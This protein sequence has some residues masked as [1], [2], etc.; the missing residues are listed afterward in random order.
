M[1]FKVLEPAYILVHTDMMLIDLGSGLRG[2]SG[3]KIGL[4]C[5]TGVT[6]CSGYVYPSKLRKSTF[7]ANPLQEV[8]ISTACLAD[9]RAQF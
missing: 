5:I 2:V 8:L 6:R 7:P 1:G 9:S 3:S 4:V